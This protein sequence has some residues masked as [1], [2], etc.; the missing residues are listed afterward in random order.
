MRLKIG[1]LSSSSEKLILDAEMEI[2][3]YYELPITK[4]RRFRLNSK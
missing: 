3:Q 2:I 4:V 1:F